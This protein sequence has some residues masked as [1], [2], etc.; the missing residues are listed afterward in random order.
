P[1]CRCRATPAGRRCS[2]PPWRR[3]APPVPHAAGPR[4]PAR[5]AGRP[6][7]AS[8]APRSSG[9]LALVGR[10]A[11]IVAVAADE[12]DLALRLQDRPGDLVETADTGEAHLRAQLV[13][14]DPLAIHVARQ[15]PAV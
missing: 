5:L 1:R 7:R 14:V 3:S 10:P 12:A 9:R 2:S 8:R 4:A 13:F 11:G 15:R 6:R